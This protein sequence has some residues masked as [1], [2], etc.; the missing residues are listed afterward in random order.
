MSVGIQKDIPTLLKV[1]GG[2]LDEGY[3]RIKLK[4]K[5]GWDTEPTR[6]VREAWPDLRLQVDA[7]SIYHLSDAAHLAEELTGRYRKDRRPL[8]ALCLNDGAHI[9]CI[10]ARRCGGRKKRGAP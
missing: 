5:P 1:V 7:N 10:I 8:A 6:A 4:I 3:T 9:T 2:Y